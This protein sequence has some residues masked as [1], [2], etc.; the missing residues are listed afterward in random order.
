MTYPFNPGADLDT[1]FGNWDD[2]VDEA[3]NGSLI[4][5][6]KQLVN[7]AQYDPT[8]HHGPEYGRDF[9]NR[10]GNFGDQ[11]D[12]T[13]TGPLI[14]QMKGFVASMLDPMR[15][16]TGLA[17]NVLDVIP[18]Q[19]HDDI[20]NN[21][22]AQDVSDY[23]NAAV[24]DAL[25]TG[26]IIFPAGTYLADQIL[27][28][29][30][31]SIIGQGGQNSIV[32]QKGA[33]AHHVFIANDWNA[34]I[35]ADSKTGVT[36]NGIGVAAAGG[37]NGGH[38]IIFYSARRSTLIN[39]SL[40]GMGNYVAST[41]KNGTPVV[42]SDIAGLHAINN[43]INGAP[44]GA[45]YSLATDSSTDTYLHNNIMSTCGGYALDG[46]PIGVIDVPN[47]SGWI[48]TANKI[49]NSPGRLLNCT[50]GGHNTIISKNEFD[51]KCS[52]PVNAVENIAVN[53]QLDHTGNM[54]FDG[55]LCKSRRIVDLTQL[56]TFLH[57]TSTTGLGFPSFGNSVLGNG[58][59]CPDG[60]P[61]FQAFKINPVDNAAGISGNNTYDTVTGLM[62]DAQM[63][64]GD[65]VWGAQFRTLSPLSNDPGKAGQLVWDAFYL[66]I[67]TA[68]NVW[69][70]VALTGGY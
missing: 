27:Y 11:L 49:Q 64:N 32:K 20:K 55:N 47:M 25:P 65:Q 40:T 13:G 3:G 31:Q 23:V 8:I 50:G 62:S 17:L 46:T 7:P 51:Y 70:R 48:I 16:A 63:G 38:G 67:C 37:S 4:A 36:F 52:A 22:S 39:C 61:S 2:V 53:I 33:N 58:F 68:P 1:R 28:F 19:Y 26:A 43:N 24:I 69:K 54:K 35:A 57:I 10:L 42:S 45:F 44:L 41:S 12:A 18:K 15:N 34:N 21:V 59:D 6:F 30:N 66:Y 9:R 5:Q 60:L 56:Y 14:A 29:D